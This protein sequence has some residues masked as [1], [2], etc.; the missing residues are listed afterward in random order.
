[1]GAVYL[2]EDQALG[3]RAAVKVISR[4]HQDET[5]RARFLREARAMATLDHPNIVRIYS[6]GEVDGAAY[7]VMEYVDGE[8]L[9]THIG[10]SG[11]LDLHEALR[12]AREI[13]AALEAAWDKGI[14]HRDVK[15][16][17]VLLDRNG[18]A[19]VADFGLAK[20]VDAGEAGLTTDGHFVGTPHYVSP[21][22]A[23]AQ[24]VDFRSDVYSLGI[25]L[26]EML[27]GERPFDAS[28]PVAV[29][30]QHLH[31]PLPSLAGRRP[32]APAGVAEL[33][34]QM[35][36]K[37]PAR[38]PDSYASL[39]AALDQL[40]NALRA[41]QTPT[42]VPTVSADRLPTP[43]PDAIPVSPSPPL[44]AVSTS[45]GGR[46]N[47]VLPWL[48]A[49]AGG[50][51]VGGALVGA[52]GLLVIRSLAGP[53]PASTPTPFPP[54]AAAP[55]GGPGVQPPGP[56]TPSST[57]AANP[58]S[59]A[60]TSGA[61]AESQGA[62]AVWLGIRV[63]G[64]EK[65]AATGVLVSG[66]LAKG[67]AERS[68]IKAGD[69]LMSLAGTELRNVL[70]LDR[71][72]RQVSVGATIRLTID[73]HGVA[74]PFDVIV[75]TLNDEEIGKEAAAP[76]GVNLADR[77]L[78]QSGRWVRGAI[79]Q[80]VAAKS[81]ADRVGLRADDA[82]AAVDGTKVSTPTE[83]A[84]ELERARRTGVV[85]LQISRAEVDFRVT[86]GVL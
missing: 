27:T 9:A 58:E 37:D 44:A 64:F 42:S 6:F 49:V 34:R 32:D 77:F 7:I 1:M 11:R 52:V 57:G 40:Q 36:A 86:I 61:A 35:T 75:D 50:M 5:A 16:Q 30:A 65:E 26:Y 43:H 71:L 83:A 23:T 46:R 25:L 80:S 63:D 2:A 59:G 69:V 20:P 33:V 73:R 70:D 79:V 51:V 31:T 54:I 24:K 67:P 66:V 21:E 14:V 56:V 29:V 47:R 15:P 18:V 17:N 74:R 13:A 41:A 22:Q 28:T 39:R 4:R 82:I 19:R 8:S 68:G 78:D 62:R 72:L 60:A 85:F 45:A 55:R 3:R 12:I 10:R 81:L 53:P 76:L 84:V 38:R 48:I